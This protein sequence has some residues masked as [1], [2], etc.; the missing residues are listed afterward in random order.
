LIVDEKSVFKEK[1]FA[2]AFSKLETKPQNQQKGPSKQQ[3]KSQNSDLYKIVRM[4]WQRNYQPVIVFSF[5]KR[6]CESNALQLSKLDFSSDDERT[7]IT[8]VFKNAISCLGEDD[9]ELPQI[10]HLLPL[11]QRGIGIHHSGLLPILK[12]VIEILFQ[13]GLIKVLF[14]TET[15]SIGLNM[16]AKTVVFTNIKKF[17]GSEQR[18]LSSGEYI[19]MSGR[20]GRRGLDDRGIVILMLSGGLDPDSV[21][22]T[23]QGKS[24]ALKSAFHQ[25]YSMILN[26]LRID[27]VEPE[28]MLQKSFYQFQNS[29]SV[30]KLEAAIAEYEEEAN[31]IKVMFEG[32]DVTCQ[33]EEYYNVRKQ[34]E[35]YRKDVRD[36]VHHPTYCLPFIQPGRLVKVEIDGSDYGWCVVVSFTKKMK[37]NSED[38]KDTV[39][40]IVS[41]LAHCERGAQD[42]VDS[43]L[44]PKPAKE[45]GEMVVIPVTLDQMFGISTVRVY[46][47]KDLRRTDSRQMML[48]SQQE[49]LRRFENKIPILDPIADMNIR[50]DDFVKLMQKI[51]K[52][53]G[54]LSKTLVSQRS[55]DPNI[56]QAYD[57]YCRRAEV[58]IKIKDLK[59]KVKQVTSIIKLDELKQRMRVLRRLGFTTNS[60]VIELKGRVACEISAGD[61]LVLTELIFNGAFTDLTPEQVVALLSCCVD[62]QERTSNEVVLKPHLEAPF[63]LLQETARRIAK[64]S[65]ESKIELNEEEYVQKFTSTMMPVAYD[66]ACGAKFVDICKTSDIFEGSI[67]RALRRL[68]ELLRQMIA[69]AKQIGN[70]DLENKFQEASA[71]IK[72]DIVFA[73][74][75]YL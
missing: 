51:E 68:E 3:Q 2:Q 24:D 7:L 17:D 60:D 14:A 12:E 66:W 4:V 45:R 10:Q 31:E 71:K 64:I 34:L 56:K 67:I 38:S 6:E 5:S 26:L 53:E 37:K 25:K 62:T 59:K 13:E 73:A 29:A 58:E 27:G 28:Y 1:N 75:L 47:Q 55:D 35:Q 32:K 9:R 44:F 50:D 61:E 52:L 57:A 18:M 39:T 23:M 41:C 36:V 72:R 40:Y 69:G 20:A 42:M 49:V 43:G 22:N 74:S 48:K 21:K 65:I 8:S 46:M 63:K 54:V 70:E 30:P 11:L 15:F 19:Q 16:P 33:M